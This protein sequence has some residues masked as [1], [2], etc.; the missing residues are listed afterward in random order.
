MLKFFDKKMKE[1]RPRAIARAQ[2]L[3]PKGHKKEKTAMAVFSFLVGH[4]G[5]SNPCVRYSVSKF[6]NVVCSHAMQ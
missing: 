2:D 4:Q 5:N 3:V 1:N 6:E